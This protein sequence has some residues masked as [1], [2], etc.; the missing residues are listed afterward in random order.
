MLVLAPEPAL[1]DYQASYRKGKQAARDKKWPEVA[2]RMR[3]ALAE[4]S[5]EGEPISSTGAFSEVYLP[6]YWLGVALFNTGDCPGAVKA[7]RESEEQLAI[8]NTPERKELTR[9]QALASKRAGCL[10]PTPEPS[11]IPSA[12]SEPRV[13]QGSEAAESVPAKAQEVVSAAAQVLTTPS[14]TQRTTPSTT[15]PNPPANVP[16]PADLVAAAQAYFSGRYEAAAGLLAKANYTSG[17]EG[18]HALLLRAAAQYA[19]YVFG[20]EKDQRLR[21]QTLANVQAC[22]QLDPT[23]NPDPKAFS[24]RFIRFFKGQ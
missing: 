13:S 3:E 21:E 16:P 7:W 5:T 6:H 10:Q 8:Q 17:R 11:P 2:Q 14:P 19:L 18:V 4:Q 24:P 15:P 12:I 23:F 1:A 20:G 9:Y 22:R